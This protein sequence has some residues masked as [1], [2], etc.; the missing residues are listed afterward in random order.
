VARY[1]KSGT[2][3]YGL[4]FLNKLQARHRELPLSGRCPYPSAPIFF[5]RRCYWVLQ[6]SLGA[7]EVDKA[8]EAVVAARCLGATEMIADFAD[9]STMMATASLCAIK[10]R[11]RVAEN[12]RLLAQR[13]QSI[14]KPPC[15]AAYL[16][17]SGSIDRFH[18]R[19]PF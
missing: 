12:V 5:H 15:L 7:S 4:N 8:D 13:Q 16:T 6:A 14:L 1:F 19:A 17:I 18:R 3:T 10:R 2:C 9:P 11:L